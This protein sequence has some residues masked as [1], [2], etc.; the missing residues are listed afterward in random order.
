MKRI[1]TLLLTFFIV[2][3]YAQEP[4]LSLTNHTKDT[5]TE[6]RKPFIQLSYQ[7]KNIP[8]G[9]NANLDAIDPSW[10]SSVTLLKD[11]S[12]ISLYGKDGADGVLIVQLKSSPEIRSFF[13]KESEI[14]RKLTKVD[15]WQDA[16]NRDFESEKRTQSMKQQFITIDGESVDFEGSS[17]VIIKHKGEELRIQSINALKDTNVELINSIE[18]LKDEESLK[19]YE[20]TKQK[21]VIILEFKEGKKANR[22]FKELKKATKRKK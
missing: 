19:K 22:A 15:L 13:E 1:A 16:S 12:A 9:K 11:N 6:S 14:Y 21:G 5:L 3:I 20:A 2:Q 8:W 4:K 10:I 17:M 18:V 7:G